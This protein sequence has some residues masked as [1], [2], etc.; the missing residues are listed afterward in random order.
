M[1][2]LHSKQFHSNYRYQYI[3]PAPSYSP[4]PHSKSHFRHPSPAVSDKKNRKIIKNYSKSANNLSGDNRNN[5]YGSGNIS[6]LSNN[7]IVKSM[8][9]LDILG[10]LRLLSTSILGN[11]IILALITLELAS[12]I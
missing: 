7:N 6:S 11:I 9:N 2:L 5:L 12:L 1:Y 4:I 3:D 8:S 10:S